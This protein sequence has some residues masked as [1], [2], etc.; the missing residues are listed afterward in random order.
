MSLSLEWHVVVG[1]KSY[2]RYGYQEF[3]LCDHM[4]DVWNQSPGELFALRAGAQIAEE[5][6]ESADYDVEFEDDD[7]VV[8]TFNAL[9]EKLDAEFSRLKLPRVDVEQRWLKMVEDF[10]ASAQG[11]E[12]SH[13]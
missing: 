4:G 12:T 3:P 2:L 5:I 7:D 10:N 1:A 6:Q 11:K 8:E 9:Q 13:E